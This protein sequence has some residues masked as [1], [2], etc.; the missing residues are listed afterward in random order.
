MAVLLEPL[1]RAWRDRGWGI[2]LAGKSS[3]SCCAAF[4]D[5]VLLCGSCAQV[6]SMYRE[7]TAALHDFALNWKP[8]CFQ[9]LGLAHCTLALPSV[10]SQV[11]RRVACKQ[12]IE[13]LGQALSYA[14]SWGIEI[15]GASPRRLQFGT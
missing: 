14:S 1:V 2:P 15:E 8:S 4:A 5:N 12:R 7:L 10:G 11:S 9:A 3:R 13:W 6:V